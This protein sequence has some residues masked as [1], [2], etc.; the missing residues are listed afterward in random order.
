[1]MSSIEESAHKIPVLTIHAGPK[2]EK[3]KERLKEELKAIITYVKMNK[4]SDND[5]FKIQSANKE[6]TKWAGTCSSTHNLVRYE[7]KLQFEV[8]ATYPSSPIEL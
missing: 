5:W 1:M 6:G 2:D 8:P 7:F 3:W 4:E